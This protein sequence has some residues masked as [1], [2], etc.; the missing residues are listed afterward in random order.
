M[1]VYMKNSILLINLILALSSPAFASDRDE[2]RS[3]DSYIFVQ[4]DVEGELVK[5][6]AR[7]IWDAES[8]RYVWSI[9][10]LA[11]GDSGNG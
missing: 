1:E 9:S 11:P 7:C 8:S 10:N 6:Y 4:K 5:F 2:C 3:G